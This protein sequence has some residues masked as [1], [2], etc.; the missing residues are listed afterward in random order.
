MTK[1]LKLNKSKYSTVEC[2]GYTDGPF[3]RRLDV[4]LS[5]SRA[6]VSCNL[7]KQLGYEVVS[8]SYVN[9]ETP[10]AKLRKVRIILGK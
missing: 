7:A 8:R 1:F 5:V 3:V 4:P 9:M 2:V 10:G 6:K